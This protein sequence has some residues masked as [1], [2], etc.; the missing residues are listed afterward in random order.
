MSIGNP[1]IFQSTKKTPFGHGPAPRQLG[2]EDSS[3]INP[4]ATGKHRTT[5]TLPET[6]I[7]PENW[8]SQPNLTK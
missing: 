8:P 2:H 6:N 4:W 7:A 3:T 1:G 5:N